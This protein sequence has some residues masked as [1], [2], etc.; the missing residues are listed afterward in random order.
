MCFAK[1]FGM[2]PDLNVLCEMLLCE[3]KGLYGRG[4]VL[5]DQEGSL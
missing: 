2:A 4:V 3:E 1:L 5:V